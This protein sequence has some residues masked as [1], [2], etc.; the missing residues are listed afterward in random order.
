MKHDRVKIINAVN[1]LLEKGR[2]AGLPLKVQP[3][4][5]IHDTGDSYQ[6]QVLVDVDYKEVMRINHRL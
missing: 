6:V 3:T 4:T 2:E 5:A 1:Y